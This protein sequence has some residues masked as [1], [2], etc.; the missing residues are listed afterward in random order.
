MP[1]AI[2]KILSDNITSCDQ[3]FWLIV[4]ENETKTSI[5]GCF[6]CRDRTIWVFFGLFVCLFV[7]CVQVMLTV[8]WLSWPELNSWCSLL[9]SIFPPYGW[10]R[11]TVI[12]NKGSH[13]FLVEI[14][15]EKQTKYIQI[16]RQNNYWFCQTAI[17]HSRPTQNAKLLH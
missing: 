8:L 12:R 4:E 6:H 7:L 9:I 10:N 5:Y 16:V 13:S 3:N 1:S 11:I 17:F 2:C 15:L 14:I